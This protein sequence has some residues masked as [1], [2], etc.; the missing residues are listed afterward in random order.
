MFLELYHSLG[1]IVSVWTLVVELVNAWD[2]LCGRRAYR[3]Y[4]DRE[5]LW[6]VHESLRSALEKTVGVGRGLA[7]IG[8]GENGYFGGGGEAVRDN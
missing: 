3:F 6:Q 5:L 4:A 8:D 1:M 2:R 7:R